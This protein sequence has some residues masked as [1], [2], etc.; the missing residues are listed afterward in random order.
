M[1]KSNYRLK[2]EI[3]NIA[4]RVN[5]TNK[6]LEKLLY[7]ETGKKWQIRAGKTYWTKPS[8]LARCSHWI[9][10][11]S[12]DDVNYNKYEN[13]FVFNTPKS[14]ILTPTCVLLYR[15][16]FYGYSE[17]EGKVYEKTDKIN[18]VHSYLKYKYFENEN[19]YSESIKTIYNTIGKYIDKVL[20]E[21]SE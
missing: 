15:N 7:E 12:E 17:E 20:E 13:D 3:E 11:I 10:A 4:Q 18:W 6:E 1:L 14:L 19:D 5:L 16:D 9:Y 2:P 21:E 8:I